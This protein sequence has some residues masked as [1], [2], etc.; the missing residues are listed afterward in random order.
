MKWCGHIFRLT[1]VQALYIHIIYEQRY[2][3]HEAITRQIKQDNRSEFLEWACRDNTV[4]CQIALIFFSIL[5]TG[6]TSASLGVQ[7][8]W[9]HIRS[10]TVWCQ[11]EQ[12]KSSCTK[13]NNKEPFYCTLRFLIILCAVD[14]MQVRIHKNKY[15]TVFS[16][17]AR[18]LP[19]KENPQIFFYA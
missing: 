3:K 16:S 15:C 14:C 10:L 4:C 12:K 9:G 11:T 13:L 5:V 8:F 7:G 2:I 18:T 6:A 1:W 19:W 17:R